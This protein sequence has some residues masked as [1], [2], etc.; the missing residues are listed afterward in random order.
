MLRQRQVAASRH[1]S[2]HRRRLPLPFRERMRVEIDPVFE[3]NVRGLDAGDR[4]PPLELGRTQD[5]QPVLLTRLAMA[6]EIG[7]L[8]EPRIH[9]LPVECLDGFQQRGVRDL[10]AALHNQAKPARGC[11]QCPMAGGRAAYE[12]S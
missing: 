12:R 7:P 1:A 10:S 3:Q 5:V 8:F 6:E 11:R 4:L 2:P 9:G